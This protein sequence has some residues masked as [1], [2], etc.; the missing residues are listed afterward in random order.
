MK[1]SDSFDW[2]EQFFD[3]MRRSMSGGVADRGLGLPMRSHDDANVRLDHDE[4]KVVVLADLPGFETE[5]I[6]LRYEDGQ[7]LLSAAH[8]VDDEDGFRSRR[9]DQR[10]RVPEDVIVEEI[11]ATYSNGVLE[12]RL[13]REYV[14]EESTHIDVN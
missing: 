4:E 13:P 3:E 7:L 9:V 1:R 2:M 10:V 11:T 5:E 12:V 8:E 6:D 14:P